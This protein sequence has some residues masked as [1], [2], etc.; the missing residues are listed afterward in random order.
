VILSSPYHSFQLSLSPRERAG[1]REGFAEKRPLTPTL[2]RRAREE[3][4]RAGFSLLTPDDQDVFA[5]KLF[6]GNR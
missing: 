2:S 5:I 4:G 6:G 3:F 1:V